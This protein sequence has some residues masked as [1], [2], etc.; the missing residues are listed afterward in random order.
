M[1]VT[2]QSIG[3]AVITTDE[4]GCVTWLN[5][6]AEVMTG[7]R[8]DEAIGRPSGQIFVI[9]H[10]KTRLP[11]ES[12]VMACLKVGAPVGL[13]AGTVLISRA[14]NEFGIED[15]AAPILSSTG[16]ILGD[17]LVFHDVTEARRTSGEMTYRATHD[18]MTGALNRSEFENRLAAVLAD[19]DQRRGHYAL[20]FIDLDQ[21]KLVN[22]N[23]G[24]SVGDDMLKQVTRIFQQA[25]RSTDSVARIGGDEFSIILANCEPAEA[26]IVAQKICDRM[27]FYRFTDDGKS[28]RIGTSI[29]L[30]SIDPHW[31]DV[32]DL[33]R[34][35]DAA[36]I[37]AKDE[38]RNRVH[39]W[40]PADGAMIQR[41][42]EM[43][44]ASRIEEAL[45]SDR[46][47]L[48]AQRIEPVKPRVGGAFLEV[49]IRL[50]EPSGA[51]TLPGA[52]LPAAERFNL[53][54]RI[55]KWVLDRTFDI[56]E[57]MSDLSK[58][59]M[60][61]INVSGKSLG[62]RGF[63]RY[64]LEKLTRAGPAVS[65]RICFEI[66]ET[67]AATNMADVTLF[68]EL[69][70]KL[71]ARIALDDFGSGWHPLATLNCFQSII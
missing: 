58:I 47:V 21:F 63:H 6:V 56:L 55:D 4:T 31:G 40:N 35:A 12:P 42:G 66:S 51:L 54:T 64:V 44:W 5:P 33:I 28:F 25:V 30:V 60:L 50:V 34:A 22:D 49:L 57:S 29:G 9:Q 41:Q 53:M 14:G 17:V 59:D 1:R 11:A 69:M 23:C 10:E 24:H 27:D 20:L 46:F 26:L 38:G 45:D 32:Q 52:F 16:I 43:R 71:G 7:W 19:K 67:A 48:F 36:C 3:D 37:V 2:L 8:N 15:S 62:D 13:A 65:S 70:H 39:V 61:G 68:I 18:P